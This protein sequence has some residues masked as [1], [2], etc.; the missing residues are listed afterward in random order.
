MSR[1]EW[2]RQTNLRDVFLDSPLLLIS[3]S[4]FNLSCLPLFP[5]VSTVS[6]AADES[7]FVAP[8]IGAL[9]IVLDD[10]FFLHRRGHLFLG[11]RFGTRFFTLATRLGTGFFACTAR[12]GTRLFTHAFALKRDKLF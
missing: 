9:G 2:R 4:R 11:A 12:L 3:T 1:K 7:I 5:M 10:S 6:L 8:G